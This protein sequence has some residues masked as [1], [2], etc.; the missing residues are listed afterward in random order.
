VPPL[1]LSLIH[2]LLNGIQLTLAVEV[3]NVYPLPLIRSVID[4]V[5][6]ILRR[7]WP[8]LLKDLVCGLP[9]VLI[10]GNGHI[11]T[12]HGTGLC[13]HSK[14]QYRESG[15]EVNGGFHVVSSVVV[16]RLTTAPNSEHIHPMTDLKARS[17]KK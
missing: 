2:L 3:Q 7:R 15:N 12:G 4:P 13:G 17:L 9:R 16:L 14:Q 8:A 5:I 6:S 10:A 1:F 11:A